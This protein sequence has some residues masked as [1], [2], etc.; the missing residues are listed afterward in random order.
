MMYPL[1]LRFFSHMGLYRVLSRVPGAAQ[2]V[3]ISYL[4][5]I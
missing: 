5:Y 4:F 3:L 2:Y 1:L